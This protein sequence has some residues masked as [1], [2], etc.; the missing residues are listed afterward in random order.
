MV[1]I[2]LSIVNYEFVS[3]MIIKKA[4]QT[5]FLTILP[6]WLFGAHIIGGELTYTC[7]GGGDYDFVLNMYRDCSNPNAGFFDQEAII[8]V[9]KGIGADA[10]LVDV[11]RVLLK[12]GLRGL[13][14]AL[15]KL[16]S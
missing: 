16:S 9:Y 13:S 2:G 10:V 6:L 11:F 5:I 1:F 8:G 7:N 14:F 15:F 12:P 4:T 3:A